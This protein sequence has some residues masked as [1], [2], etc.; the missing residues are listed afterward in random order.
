MNAHP[1]LD[2]PAALACAH[3]LLADPAATAAR[4][5]AEVA[6]APCFANRAYPVSPLPVLVAE[7]QARRLA[8]LA[9]D[10]V[11]LLGH[12]VRLYRRHPE[13]R[14]WYGLDPAAERLV[15]ADAESVD[16][17]WICRLDGYLEHGSERLAVL[18]NNA[19]A[20][21]GTLF[22]ARVNQLVKRV[23]T[24][25]GVAGESAALTYGGQDRFL[26]ALLA[27]ATRIAAA[28]GKQSRPEHIA[29]LQ[30]RGGAN[31][32]SVEMVAEF[33]D[34]GYHAFLADPRDLRVAGAR[35]EFAGQPADLCWNKVNTVAWTAL[36]ADPEFV[37]DWERA[38]RDTSLVHLNPFGAR[39]VAEHK[40]SLAFVQ[41]PE[42]AELFT[43]EQREL[44]AGLVPPSRKVTADG[45]TADG[46]E[47]L[48]EHVLEHQHSHVLKAGYDIRGDGVTI[49]PDVPRG[50][51]RAAVRAAVERGYVAQRLVRPV[52]YP[53]LDPETAAVTTKSIS[54]DSYVLG[55]KLAGFGAKAS[56]Q[57]KVNIFQGGQKLA[58]HVMRG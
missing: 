56:D 51:W 13:V 38:L 34:R 4:T 46:T 30:P 21:A 49:G 39:Y 1:V 47:K 11:A 40:L 35:A 12:V 20:P 33:G 52:A 32:E 14:A 16:I 15:A 58:V 44:A 45:L 2:W 31:R 37:R 8:G 29:I 57:M 17:P 18:E 41:D 10:Y 24:G 54:L 28:T 7:S 19:D 36:T 6:A 22:T 48:V 42:F 26:T 3:R 55:G 9:E 50:V 27:G 25:I 23:L 5:A 43:P 53:V